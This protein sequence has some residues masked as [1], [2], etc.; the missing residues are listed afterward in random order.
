MNA[1]VIS[2]GDEL[3]SGQT[4]DTNSAWLSAQL[5]LLGIRTVR[6]I[7]VA[8]E[9][10]PIIATLRDATNEAP[11][12]LVTG[13]LGPTVDDLSRF[14]LAALLGTELELHPPSRERIQAFFTARNRAMPE[15]NQIQAMFPAGSTPIEN[16]CGT[17]PGIAAACGKAKVFMMP[18]VPREMRTMFEISIK[19]ILRTQ[20]G[21][22]TIQT[23][24]LHCCGAGESDIGRMIS[25]L[26][27]RDRNPTVG[28][29]AKRGTVGIRVQAHGHS[30]SEAQQLADETIAEIR[31]RVGSLCFGRDEESLAWAV[32]EQLKARGQTLATAES[33]TGGLIAKLLTDVPGSSAYFLDGVVSYANEAKTRLLDVPGELIDQHGAVSAPVAEAMANGCRARSNSDYAISVTG[34]AGPEGGTSDKPVGLVFI[35]LAGPAGCSVTEQQFGVFG[36][37]QAIRERTALTA[38]NTLR[39]QLLT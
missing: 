37:R 23:T 2:I 12:V 13:G 16:S 36:D 19:P 8:D 5:A 17:A 11:V 38:L 3:T 10:E 32:G 4:V 18:G 7:T 26:M 20:A 31:R 1:I 35:G 24:V 14:A 30:P 39:L 27:V 34:I 9:L 29:T 25:D 6:Q 28:T 21:K 15:A 33:C 22:A